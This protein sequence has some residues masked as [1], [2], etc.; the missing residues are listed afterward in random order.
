[1]ETTTVSAVVLVRDSKTMPGPQP[2]LSPSH[3]PSSSRASRSATA[4][5]DASA[6]PSHPGTAAETLR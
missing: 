4:Q 1:M 5:F 6:L 3:R 2:S